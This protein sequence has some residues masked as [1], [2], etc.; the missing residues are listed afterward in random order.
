MS[1]NVF[2][3]LMT[4]VIN[5]NLCAYC[6][7]CMASC[8]VNVIYPSDAEKPILKG[9]CVLC[10]ICYYS[11]PRV[12]YDK[13]EIEKEIF[14]REK[15]EDETL[16]IFKSAYFARSKDKDILRNC[17][18]G[19][20]ATSILKYALE[21]GVIDCVAA[22]SSDELSPLKP[23]SRAIWNPVDLAGI[24]GTRY[25]IGAGVSELREAF[26]NFPQG[27]IAFTGIPCEIQGVRKMQTTK[28]A[29]NNIIEN[30]DFSLG[31]FCSKA[32][33]Y[34]KLSTFIDKQ[35]RVGLKEVVRTEIKKG[36]FKAFNK[37]REELVNTPIK[38]L[39]KLTRQGCKSCQD[40]TAELADISVG[41]AGAPQGWSIVF[42]R[43]DRGEKIY[44][45][46]YDSGIIQSRSIKDVK[47]KLSLVFKLADVKKKNTWKQVE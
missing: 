34:D 3:T 11:C 28:I 32:F 39:S 35:S 8:P 4:K 24:S 31:I 25:S 13:G 43:T 7:T 17:Q 29:N 1:L 10:Q 33:Y 42:T 21:K 20:V 22:S 12:K 40:Y 47:T 2:G 27:K 45:N 46:A 9:R 30:L 15:E 6:G 26:E 38:D 18:D 44:K 5:T 41:G 16:G 36:K 23:K 14:G 37:K 19:G